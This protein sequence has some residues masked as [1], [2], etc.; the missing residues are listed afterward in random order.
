MVANEKLAIAAKIKKLLAKADSAMQFSTAEEAQA[1]ADKAAALMEEHELEMTDIEYADA[2]TSDPIG[3]TWVAPRDAK[4]NEKRTRRRT[5]WSEDLAQV[6]AHHNFCAYMVQTSSPVIGFTGRKSH[7]EVV[8]FLF[9][10]LTGEIERICVREDS[11]AW[12]KMGSAARGFP[13]SFKRGF[14]EA[15]RRRLREAAEARKKE[16]EATG[17]GTALIRLSTTREAAAKYQKERWSTISAAAISGR[18]SANA[19]GRQVGRE[20]GERANLTGN[21]LNKGQGGGPKLLK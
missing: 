13:T 18:M 1:F 4:S 12:A 17:T 3:T 21:G 14:V 15:V 8:A 2:L 20:Y 16:Q 7:R 6:L 9:Q 19:Y 10:T 11:R 5:A